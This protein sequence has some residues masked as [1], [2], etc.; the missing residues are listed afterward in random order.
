[1]ESTFKKEYEKEQLPDGSIKLSYTV[2]L[3][4][5]YRKGREAIIYWVYAAILLAGA[6]ALG[7][8]ISYV[9]G[10]DN[11]GTSILIGLA[12]TAAVFFIS[13]L[14]KIIKGI[15]F[16]KINIIVKK[17]GIIFGEHQL[18]FKDISDLGIGTESIH[19]GGGV[20]T[21]SHVFAFSGGQ[22]INITHKLTDALANAIL[23]EIKEQAA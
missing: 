10:E 2:Y 13:P 18:A 1:M 6:L 12:I 14:P 19:R 17:E 7:K 15:L 9:I 20:S 11:V 16:R 5:V 8:Q 22:K 21:N 23:N 4:G 3:F